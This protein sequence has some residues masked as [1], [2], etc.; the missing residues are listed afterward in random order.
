MSQHQAKLLTAFYSAMTAVDQTVTVRVE[1]ERNIRPSFTY[2]GLKRYRSKNVHEWHSVLAHMGEPHLPCV[3]CNMFKGASRKI[4]RHT[5]GKPREIRAG[6]HWDMD[7]ITFRDRSEEGCRSTALPTNGLPPHQIPPIR[8]MAVSLE[9]A[10]RS[11]HRAAMNPLRKTQL[12][13]ALV[14]QPRSLL[15][16][17]LSVLVKDQKTA[18]RLTE[19]K[20]QPTLSWKNIDCCPRRLL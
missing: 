1:G 4:K 3:V 8:G 14:C 18:D 6:Y 10:A 19:I 17:A 11:P 20:D 2:G 16:P 9:T 12:N 15:A 13:T 7:M 5:H